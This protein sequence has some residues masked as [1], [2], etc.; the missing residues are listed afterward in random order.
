VI[1]LV[2]TIGMSFDNTDAV[3]NFY[4]EYVITKVFG[5]RTSSKKGPD[6]KLRYFMWVCARAGKYTSSISTTPFQLRSMNVQ[7]VLLLA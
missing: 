4:R 3:K 2:P 5:I 7:L 1:E 6:N